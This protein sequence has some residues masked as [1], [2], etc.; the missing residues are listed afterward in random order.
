MDLR[1]VRIAERLRRSPLLKVM[2]HAL[3]K[4]GLL[5][6]TFTIYE[7]VLSVGS[8]GFRRGSPPAHATALPI[9]P[10]HLRVLV[11]GSPDVDSFLRIGHSMFQAL[12]ATLRQ[13]GVPL[14]ELGTILEFG[15]GCGR[16]LRHWQAVRGPKVYAVDHSDRLITW[17]RANLPFARCSTNRSYPP[18]PFEDG[19][20]DFVYAISVFTHLSEPLQLAWMNEL[21]RVVRSGG[22]LLITTHGATHRDRLTP[23][24]H[25]TFDAGDLVVRYQEAS[26]MNLCTV[27]HPEA[28]VRSRMGTGVTVEAFIPAGQRDGV[29]QDLYLMR[30]SEDRPTRG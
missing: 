12:G 6:A 2:L 17:C 30:K 1:N 13:N 19:F 16:V 5:R 9:P 10:S 4:L 26:G 8:D 14:E 24:E 11:G 15:C 27:Y 3:G 20:F 23:T 29:H 18:L 25:R 7:R 21:V 22:H 28:Y